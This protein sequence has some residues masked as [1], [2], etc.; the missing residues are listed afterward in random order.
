MSSPPL[1]D[2]ALVSAGLA[3]IATAPSAAL[4]HFTLD[5]GLTVYLREDHRTPLVA[6]QALL[7]RG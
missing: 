6:V 2:D 1:P 4:Q 5:N 3:S 7:P